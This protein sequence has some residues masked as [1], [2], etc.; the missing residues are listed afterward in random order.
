MAIITLTSDFGESDHY[1]GALKGTILTAD[2]SQVIVDI[3]HHIQNFD[4]SHGAFVLKSSYPTFPNGSIHLV[5]VDTVGNQGNTQLAVQLD[6]H[7]FLLNDHGLL[8]LISDDE[9]QTVVELPWS[10]EQPSTFPALEVLAPAAIAL[11]KGTSIKKLGKHRSE[12]HKMVGRRMRANKHE[13]IGHVVRVDHY[14]NLITNIGKEEFYRLNKGKEYTILIG[15]EKFRRL[16]NS[17]NET[18]SGDCFVIFNSLGLLEVG[19]N[20]GNASELMGLK[21]DSPIKISFEDV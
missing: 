14:G 16:N 7:F 4:L 18:G 3:T 5:A 1:V 13:I 6:D 20:K 10:Q 19:I 12:Y 15:R 11:A 9:P 21:F 8:G 2:P 17:I